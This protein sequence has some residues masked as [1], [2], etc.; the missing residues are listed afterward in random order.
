MEVREYEEAA[1][2]RH[3][4]GHVGKEYARD[5]TIR[6]LKYT[7]MQKS[8]GTSYLDLGFIHRA[9][10]HQEDESGRDRDEFR[11]EHEQRP[12]VRVDATLE[13]VVLPHE[14]GQQRHANHSR[15]GDSEREERLSGEHREYLA[16]DAKAGSAMM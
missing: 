6:K 12:H 14:E 9:H 15:R 4:H 8:I 2:H 11:R 3:V 10:S 5:T 13:E 1:V 16:Y 7:A